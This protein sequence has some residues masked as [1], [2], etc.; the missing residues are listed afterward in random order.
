MGRN[1]AEMKVKGKGDCGIGNCIISS[2]AK[3]NKRKRAA[4]C[5]IRTPDSQIPSPW[6]T[7]RCQPKHNLST[8]AEKVAVRDSYLNGLICANGSASGNTNIVLCPKPYRTSVL[9]GAR[10]EHTSM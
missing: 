8:I 4:Q 7:S 2:T 3:Q 6:W 9:L 5:R 1:V 10:Q